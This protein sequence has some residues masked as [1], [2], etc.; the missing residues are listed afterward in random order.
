VLSRLLRR[1]NVAVYGDRIRLATMVWSVA[2]LLSAPPSGAG[3]QEPRADTNILF[4]VEFIERQLLA[5]R[6]ELLNLDRSRP[7]DNDRNRR[8]TLAG[9]DGEP[10]MDVHWKPVAPP[11]TGFNN[12]PRYELAAYRLQR[13]FLDEA[14]YVVPPTV[15]RAM[16]VEEHRFILPLAE[17]TIRFTQSVLFLLSYWIRNLGVD[18]VDPFDRSLFDMDE[19][20]ARHFANAN[21]LTYLIEHKDGNHGNLLVS[22]DAFNRR[23]FSVDNDVSFRSDRSDKGVRWRTLHVDRLPAT[24]VAR[25]RELTRER[26]DAELAVL[27]EFRIVNGELEAVPPGEN[28]GVTRGLRIRDDRVQFGL[29]RAEIGDVE[30]RIQRLLSDVDRGRITTF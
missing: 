24:T 15:L 23:V 30:R 19:V 29:T 14:E 10:L 6:L 2:L 8:V 1:F 25:L 26:L 27:A 11:G 22:M 7:I 17:P 9:P 4:P 5:P 21:T 3:A 18:T 12:E 13:L 28:L 20:Y 16:P